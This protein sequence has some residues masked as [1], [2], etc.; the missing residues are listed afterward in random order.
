D[1][2]HLITPEPHSSIWPIAVLDV[3]TNAA[4]RKLGHLIT[5]TS[6]RPWAIDNALTFHPEDKL[7]TVLWSLAGLTIPT[8]TI[9]G[10]AR[11]RDDPVVDDIARWLGDAEAAAFIA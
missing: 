11:L 8:V 6:G 7:R 3:L 10:V 4:D 1:P 2:R 5:D 9:E